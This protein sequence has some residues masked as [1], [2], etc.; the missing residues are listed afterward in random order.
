MRQYGLVWCVWRPSL[1]AGVRE[2]DKQRPGYEYD[3]Q[4]SSLPP[5]AYA[6]AN[7]SLAGSLL[8]GE[9]LLVIAQALRQHLTSSAVSP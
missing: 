5:P 3:K 9:G 1:A 4:L 7:F 8:N 6:P 2:Y